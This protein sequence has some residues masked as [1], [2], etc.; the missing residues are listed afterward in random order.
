M[1]Q[2]QQTFVK[3]CE[4]ILD[5]QE[6]ALQYMQKSIDRTQSMINELQELYER[7][8]KARAVAEQIA[9]GK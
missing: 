3:T 5:E 9:S 7:E 1:T 6:K 2:Y 8:Q 4:K